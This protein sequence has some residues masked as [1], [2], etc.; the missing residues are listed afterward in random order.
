MKKVLHINA[1]GNQGFLIS[2]YEKSLGF[3]SSVLTYKKN[4]YNFFDPELNYNLPT[5]LKEVTPRRIYDSIN[6][7]IKCSYTA[8]KENDII[9]FYGGHTFI[10]VSQ[11]SSAINSWIYG[12][13]LHLLKDKKVFIHYQGCEVRKKENENLMCKHCN[14]SWCKLSTNKWKSKR[15][16]KVKKLKP[17][18]TVSTPDLLSFVPSNSL[19][20]PQVIPITNKPVSKK[21]RDK[22][23]IIHGPTN[24]AKKGTDY[25][26]RAVRE[27]KNEGYPFELILAQNMSH[28]LLINTAKDC[29]LAIDQ[30]LSGWYGRFAAEMMSLGVPTMAYIN[31][32]LNNKHRIPIISY[33]PYTIKDGLREVFSK[34][35]DESF[36]N[37]LRM[38]SYIYAKEN[39]F[40]DAVFKKIADFY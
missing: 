10:P 34:F 24:P 5:T 18:V 33:D 40:V 16:D 7:I 12:L 25:I 22:I 13:D 8:I 6:K 9:H 1:A 15:V 20:L 3:E 31:P 36:Y 27:L 14:Q 23:K 21:K 35:Q 30:V 28:D 11:K 37:N 4:K 39:H 19:V 26:L 2:Q 17:I 38:E 32:S 29:D